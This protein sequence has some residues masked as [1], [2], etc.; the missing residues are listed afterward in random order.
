M[1]KR[2]V[3]SLA[4]AVLAGGLTQARAGFVFT[5]LA[6]PGAAETDALGINDGGQIVGDYF[7]P[8]GNVTF[9]PYQGFLLSGGSYSTIDFPGSSWT[10]AFDINNSGQIVGDE[11]T[12]QIHGFLLDHGSYTALDVPGGYPTQALGLN[13]NGQVVGI[14]RA[15]DAYHGFLLS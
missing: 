9:G 6:F 3:L 13:D 1:A 15:P 11:I 2:F 8:G 7:N 4:A 10:R 14:Y 12:G 5:N